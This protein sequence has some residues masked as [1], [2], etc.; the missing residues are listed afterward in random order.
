MAV[1]TEENEAFQ[2]LQPIETDVDYNTKADYMSEKESNLKGSGVE[3]NGVQSEIKFH[4][5]DSKKS[6]D[7]QK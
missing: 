2:S 7:L 1:T 3:S 4:R 5:Q 6:E